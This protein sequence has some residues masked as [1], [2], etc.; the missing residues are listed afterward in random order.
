ML[1]RAGAHHTLC[2]KENQ[3][4][5]LFFAANEGH[6][7]CARLLLSAGAQVDTVDDSGWTPFLHALYAGHMEAA[8]LMRCSP[9]LAAARAVRT[10]PPSPLVGSLKPADAPPAQP[11]QQHAAMDV[12]DLDGI[13]SLALPPPILPTKVYGHQSLKENA[14][15]HVRLGGAGQPP[16]TL[17]Y[18]LDMIFY[19]FCHENVLIFRV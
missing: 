15:L 2:D 10:S 4:T 8:A 7:G 5:P 12:L 11:T 14:Q 16:L 19:V 17:V 18:A 9:E 13:P 6:L 1:L 3:W